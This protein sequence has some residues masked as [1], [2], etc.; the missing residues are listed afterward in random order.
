MTGIEKIYC[1]AFSAY[2]YDSRD[3]ISLIGRGGVKSVM[4]SNINR[5]IFALFG[6]LCEGG[7]EF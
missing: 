3:E 2:R 1:C 7:L 4:I 6:F 5:E